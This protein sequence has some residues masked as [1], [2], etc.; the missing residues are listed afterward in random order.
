MNTRHI[1]QFRRFLGAFIVATS[2]VGCAAPE[3]LEETIIAVQESGAKRTVALRSLPQVTSLPPE[4]RLVGELGGRGMFYAAGQGPAFRIDDGN[5]YHGYD[6][7]GVWAKEAEGTRTQGVIYGVEGDVIVSAGYLIRQVDLV[8]GKSF[9][10]LTIRE[11]DFPAAH[12]LTIDFLSGETDES[13]QY[14]LLVHFLT[15]D[16]EARPML[17]LGQLPSVSILP[18]E[19]VV[20][21]CDH[22]PETRFCPGMGRHFTDLTSVSRPSDAS[23]NEGLVYGEAAGKLIFIEYVFTQE[24]LKA[25]VSWPAMPLNDLPIPPIDNIHVLHFGNP[26]TTDGRYTVHMYFLPE[27]TYLN[28]EEEPEKL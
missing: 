23:G 10:G 15:P 26:E 21:A 18:D 6:G 12:S 14:L 2:L 13:N 25:G 17:P 1:G 5:H 8:D 4:Y 24:E 16:G 3:A 9:H 27:E 20:F 19:F 7:P 28:W 11:L 22:Y